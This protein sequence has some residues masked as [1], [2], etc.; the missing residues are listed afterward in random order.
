MSRMKSPNRGKTVS[1]S[2]TEE[3]ADGLDALADKRGI[4]RS[5]LLR[6]AADGLLDGDDTT[7]DSQPS[8]TDDGL[9]KVYDACVELSNQRLILP[10]SEEKAKLAQMTQYPQTSL[11][12]KLG[13]LERQGFVRRQESYPSSQRT[14]VCY[15][16]KPPEADPDQW[17]YRRQR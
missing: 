12:S 4:S 9:R 16:I 17:V 3:Q 5:E 10:F 11:P 13:K 6:Q 15:R 2:T 1:F 7:D 14:R 8:P